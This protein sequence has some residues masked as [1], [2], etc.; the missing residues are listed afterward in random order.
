MITVDE[1]DIIETFFNRYF[2]DKFVG[3]N[4]AVQTWEI[5]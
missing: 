4:H 3:V 5:F 1:M 2:T